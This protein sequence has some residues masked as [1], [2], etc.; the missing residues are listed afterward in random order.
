[1]Q[2][3]FIVL[4]GSDGSGKG[5][6]FK[7]LS[8]RLRAEG[9]DIITFDFPRY[10]QSSSYFVHGYLNGMY[11]TPDEVGPYVSSLFYALDRY[12]TAP[13]IREALDEGKIVLAN[14][15]TPSN[16]AHQGAKIEADAER[17][18]FFLWVDNLE[19]KMMG[20]PRPNM[21]IVLRVP[22]EIAQGLVDKKAERDYTAKKRDVH[23]ADIEHLKRS[24][25][26]YDDLCQLFP[27][28]F[29]RIDCV[30]G[31]QLLDIDTIHKLLWESVK[32][33]LPVKHRKKVPQPQALYHPRPNPY[34]EKAASGYRLTTAG[35]GFLKAVVSDTKGDVYTFTKVLSPASIAAALAHVPHRK[36]DIRTIILQELAAAG[37]NDTELQKKAI[38]ERGEETVGRLAGQHIVIQG[39]TGLVVSKFEQDGLAT[40]VEAPI[41]VHN[42]K[43]NA[44]SNHYYIPGNF[45]PKTK[46]LYTE[47]MDE[48]LSHYSDMAHKLADYLDAQSSGAKNKTHQA[49]DTSLIQAHTTL[50]AVLPVAATT[51]VVLYAPLNS[52][53]HLISRL[54][55][56]EIPEA[57]GVAHKM[58]AQIRRT[59]PAFLEESELSYESA[60]HLTS[61]AKTLE[62]LAEKY[63]PA[64]NSA[65]NDDVQ[66]ITV[67]PRNELDLLPD[68]LYSRSNL[69][70]RDI[71]EE[72]SKWPYDQKYEVFRAYLDDYVN[73]RHYPGS[74]LE[75][76][77]YSW[78]IICGYDVF[79]EMQRYGQIKTIQPQP[80]SPRYGYDV[81]DLIDNA[82]LAEDFQTCFD[83]S[84]ELYSA[85]Q[86]AGY[87]AEAQYAALL[88]HKI[89][90]QVTYN[91]REA[92]KLHK[93]Q[94]LTQGH[95]GHHKLILQMYEKLSEVHPLLTETM[96]SANTGKDSELARMTAERYAQY[97][98]KNLSG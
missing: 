71:Q 82:G 31:G 24:V 86:Q 35:R 46:G 57:A 80:L 89:R 48:I 53:Q 18:G 2:G 98:L 4:E 51:N 1:M 58:L 6:Q 77:H 52:L 13:A 5:T 92:F 67:W 61:D 15:F 47:T 45:D 72:V 85:M 97:K 19:F 10:D 55:S 83:M 23:E 32:P 12:E 20:I 14:R 38:K 22:A 73:K 28:D 49:S 60:A 63:L 17:R 16:M 26:T 94:A 79:R 95:P 64:T 74:A 36:E 40:C 78:D 96:E 93:L 62:T 56:D 34:I 30:R 69:P 27:K 41:N 44:S 25:N 81:P 88:G 11:G 8:D 42:K 43:A 54:L 59:L 87:F 33:L 91:A 65:L 75:K 70:L 50:R 76:V 66:L 3:T 84:L 68:I 9:H 21:S 39:V 7:L 29:K 37:G 90:L